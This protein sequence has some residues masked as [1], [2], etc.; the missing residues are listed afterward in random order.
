MLLV[1]RCGMPPVACSLMY[2]LSRLRVE[3]FASGDTLKLTC[4]PNVGSAH[5]MRNE[6]KATKR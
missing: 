3:D 5:G 2:A 4:T 1:A 6:V